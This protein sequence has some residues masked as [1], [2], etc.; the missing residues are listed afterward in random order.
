MFVCVCFSKLLFLSLCSISSPPAADSGQV[1]IGQDSP[2]KTKGGPAQL[3]VGPNHRVLKPRRSRSTVQDYPKTLLSQDNISSTLA[4]LFGLNLRVSEASRRLDFPQLFP[5][6]WDRTP[7]QYS[8][9]EGL[10]GDSPGF[11]DPAS[12]DSA[13]EDFDEDFRLLDELSHHVESPSTDNQYAGVDDQALAATVGYDV[14][15]TYDTSNLC[16]GV[17]DGDQCGAEIFGE[18]P[19]MENSLS[20]THKRKRSTQVGLDQRDEGA[21][22]VVDGGDG[23]RKPKRLPR[24]INTADEP[25]PDEIQIFWNKTAEEVL[26]WYETK[27]EVIPEPT[28]AIVK[29]HMIQCRLG[30]LACYTFKVE[31]EAIEPEERN[32]FTSLIAIKELARRTYPVL[33][34]RCPRC[35]FIPRWN[36]AEVAG[37]IWVK[38]L[39]GEALMLPCPRAGCKKG[40]GTL[41][42]MR[43]HLSQVHGKVKKPTS[44]S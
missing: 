24:L 35:E 38:H 8:N 22:S 39:K 14:D 43:R 42:Q 25:Y 6:P 41:K 29:E 31:I 20:P 13:S 21:G 30:G 36:A 26:D 10:G 44:S 17:D 34:R 37:H 2:P 12:D 1:R 18:Q 7:L 9:F 3:A 40:F 28:R 4:S 19:V 27:A 32:I 11:K 5:L 23:E 15:H 33:M 16:P